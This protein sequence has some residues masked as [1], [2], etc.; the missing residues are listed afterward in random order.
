MGTIDASADTTLTTLETMVATDPDDVASRRALIDALVAGGRAV[1]A[2]VH[3][4]TIMSTHPDNPGGYEA[5]AMCAEAVADRRARAFA[6]VAHALEGYQEEFLPDVWS[7]FVPPEVA[8]VAAAVADPVDPPEPTDASAIA[9]DD[10]T[11][12]AVD[13]V[14]VE[15]VP[16]AAPAPAAL[17]VDPEAIEHPQLAFKNIIGVDAVKRRIVQVVLDPLRTTPRRQLG[18]VLMFGPPGCG[19]SFFARTVAGE[20]SSGFL[21]VEMGTTMQWPGDPRDNVHRLFSAARAAT[22]CVLFLN[23][24]DLAGIRV[25][26]EAAPDRRLLSRLATELSNTAANRGL[27]ILAASTAP[28]NVDVSL[29]A[30]G[31]IDRTLL[32]VPPDARAREAILRFQFQT[33]PLAGLDV[34]WIVERTEHFSGNDLLILC[35]RAQTLASGDSLGGTPTVGPGHMTRALREVRPSAPTWFSHAMDYAMAANHEGMYDDTLSYIDHH[36]LA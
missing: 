20:L 25:G 35:E 11:S 32:V 1:E 19:K 6:R 24:I 26:E 16:D 8:P 21:Q 14:T 12:P 9:D 28:W 4:E 18:G 15:T 5:A 17:I 3:A 29:R 30:G 13:E 22:P 36:R 34:A 7:G 27:T 31:A 10:A 23:D 33:V 2:M